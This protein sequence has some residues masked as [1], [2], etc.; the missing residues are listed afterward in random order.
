MSASDPIAAAAD[1]LAKRIGAA[2]VR[3]PDGAPLT[4]NAAVRRRPALIVRPRSSHDVQD[5]VRVARDRG[6]PLSV[7]GGGHDW[8]GRAL[9]DGGW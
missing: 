8:A 4:W 6:I 2:H 1:D 7:L 3:V 9:C 5:A